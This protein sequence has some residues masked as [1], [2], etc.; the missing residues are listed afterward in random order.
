MIRFLAIWVT[1]AEDFNISQT[2]DTHP[3]VAQCSALQTAVAIQPKFPTVINLAATRVDE[4]SAPARPGGGK[5]EPR[6]NEVD[7]YCRPWKS[8]G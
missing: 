2:V 5:R 6:L 8:P 4:V 7:I 3:I 1:Q